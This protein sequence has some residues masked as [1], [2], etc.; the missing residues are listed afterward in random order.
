[1]VNQNSSSSLRYDTTGMNTDNAPSRG[2]RT[3]N[4][5]APF[6]NA[7]GITSN[8]APLANARETSRSQLEI[9][10]INLHRCR[11][12]QYALH[13]YVDKDNTLAILGQ[14]PWTIGNKVAGKIPGTTLF[15]KAASTRP[16]A[17]V[18]TRGLQA[19]MMGQFSNR[20]MVTVMVSG[21]LPGGRKMILTS[22]YMAAEEP[23]P[24]NLLRELVEHCRAGAIPLLVGTD[25]NS[26]HIAWG[27]SDTNKRGEDLMEFIAIEG[28]DW[29]NRGNQPTFITAKRREVLDITLVNESA[30]RLASQW[31]VAEEDSLSDHRYIR[32]TIANAIVTRE[33]YR[34]LRKANWET[35]NK[36]LSKVTPQPGEP[37]DAEELERRTEEL[38]R[39]VLQALDRACPLRDR[40]DKKETSW[41]SPGLERM[42][43]ECEKWQ[44]RA[45][46]RGCP[47]TWKTF[48]ELRIQYAKSIR[49][50]KRNTWKQ[51]TEELDSLPQV[52]RAVKALGNKDVAQLGSVQKPDGSLTRSPTETLETMLQHHVPTDNR[53]VAGRVNAGEVAGCDEET[54]DAITRE[55]RMEEALNAFHPYK[56]PGP[57]GIPPVALKNIW[58]TPLRHE[59]RQIFKA[60]LRLGHIPRR[61]KRGKGVFLPKP[62]K[63]SYEKVN[64]YRMVTLTDFSLKWLERLVLW[65]LERDLGV[66]QKMDHRQ[67]GFKK[68]S[69]TETALHNLVRRIEKAME[70][71]K[72]ALG[73]FIDI[74]NAFPT[75]S[76]HG[77]V[78]ALVRLDIPE[79]IRRWIGDMLRG[80]TIT[81]RL[82]DVEKDRET[83]LGCPQGGILS[84]FL[85]NAVMD[86]LLSSLRA[87][88][89]FT[90][91]YADD[92]VGLFTGIDPP[93]LVDHAQTFLDNALNWAQENG[94]TLSKAKTEAV[95]FTRKKG[96]RPR[97]QLRIQGTNVPFSKEAKYLGVWLDGKLNFGKHIEERAKKALRVGAQANRMAGKRWGLTPAKAHWIYTSMVRPIMTYGCL[98]WIKG[99]LVQ[100][101]VKEL[102]KVQR[103]A[104]LMMTAGRK[105]APQ[106]ALEVMMGLKP[107]DLELKELAIKASLR[108]TRTGQWG[109]NA[110]N[111]AKGPLRT[112]TDII[113]GWRREIPQL[114][115][116]GDG[117]RGLWMPE[118][119]FQTAIGDRVH[120]EQD[121]RDS[122]AEVKCFTDG[123][124]L[125]KGDAGAGMRW[126]GPNGPGEERIHLGKNATV[127]QAEITALTVAASCMK[128][129]GLKGVTIDIFTDS[130]AAIRTLNREWTA[131]KTTRECKQ[132]LNELARENL[133][134]VRWIPGHVGVEGNE[135]ADR[136][137]KEAAS[138]KVE[139]PLPLLP[140]PETFRRQLVE[141]HVEK[142]RKK[143]WR[144]LQTCEVS[145]EAMPAP[146]PR[147]TRK[148]L[149]KSRGEM[150]RLTQII[151]GHC[152]LAKQAT[153]TGRLRDPT[154]PKCWSE[155]ETTDHH[156]G[157]CLYYEKEREECFG[158][159]QTSIQEII[160]K[161]NIAA[162]STYLKR[163]GRL[164][165]ARA[166]PQRE[167][168]T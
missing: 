128:Q 52:S 37:Q 154:C 111:Q 102:R 75:V 82:L 168:S 100:A 133:V 84:P 4:G 83:S 12:A 119:E 59:Y 85:W 104:C 29:L 130:Q 14:E 93:T 161:G 81:A 114:G 60:S 120:A 159:R 138:M 67:F 24:P 78:K 152:D 70:S 94:L 139:G 116:P 65:H 79:G 47:K 156:V 50:A 56:S 15:T 3:R 118:K 106:A 45:I 149:I 110:T 8:V 36:A 7:R 6:A 17:C 46:V 13:K 165:E 136:V 66:H 87:Q 129:S 19:W 18:I 89:V 63:D 103:L 146:N 166:T 148:L 142:E 38:E 155:R 9:C 11:A 157:K 23:T 107:I 143:E 32:C 51:F 16:R 126:E 112:H 69:S 162:L 101:N 113:N 39:K 53:S 62:G 105:S 21:A 26:H 95:V 163:T 144:G 109:A 140:L 160:R 117:M 147:M 49:R 80:R 27:S 99:I 5:V 76:E 150:W 33:Q 122:M 164:E 1:M 54:L 10:Q 96:W 88:L 20:D 91:A 158:Q 35:F 121:E 125:E 97:R 167:G 64:A 40:G 28:L 44:K 124:K 86:S 135:A 42:K 2:R 137:A 134:T 43:K 61:W 22:V 31:R 71:E 141:E 98:V 123:S 74:E 92:V 132:R 73:I 108:L 115:L 41:W 55:E 58:N 153:T 72:Y 131:T 90:Q 25:A 77:I 68:E 145:R 57:D 48:R 30:S 34:P 151:T 127:F